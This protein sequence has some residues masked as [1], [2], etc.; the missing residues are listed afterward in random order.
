VSEAEGSEAGRGRPAPANDAHPGARHKDSS[1]PV[2]SV[3]LALIGRIRREQGYANL[4]LSH[5]AELAALP[6]RD[7]G[8]VTRLVYGTL[9]MEGSLDAALKHV[10]ERGRLSAPPAVLDALRLGAYQLL[11][12]D[13]AVHAAVGETVQTIT[14]HPVAR[15]RS[16][17]NALL[18]RLAQER[19]GFP[20]LERA[21]HPQEWLALRYGHPRWLV[22]R[23]L[24][25][26]GEAETEEL[27]AA[28]DEAPVTHIRAN[29][30]RV[31][32]DDLLA[33]LL[34]RGYDARPGTLPE[35]ILVA[36]PPGVWAEPEAGHEFVV[37]DGGSLLAPMLLDPKPGEMVLDMAAGRGGKATHLAALMGN[38]GEV[39]A[40]DVHAGKARQ[41]EALARDM[42]AGIV[43]CEVGDARSW[44]PEA[45]FD[46]VLLD[47]PCS[48]TGT[49]RRRAELRWRRTPE[50]VARVADLQR[51]LLDAA[52]GHV[53]AGGR[54]VYSTCS[55]LPEENSLQIDG[56]LA[57]ASGT[58]WRLVRSEQLL[59]SRDG[60]D[61]HFAALL[62]R[63]T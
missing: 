36:G 42:G 4:V 5:S 52:A 33:K 27:L 23:L 20:W 29:T 50:D 51:T 7:R 17:A 8:L 41:C 15:W 49:L 56:F 48:G 44:E 58:A 37:Q 10:T 12:S 60:T 61:G 38:D 32:R 30:L 62:E 1:R 39:V 16:L 43:R 54:L 25:A 34:E 6:P 46:A 24:A 19:E 47:A 55:I 9:Q 63:G 13:V 40:L 28:D 35:G 26:Y 45:R 2:R 59:P 22:E 11:F 53:R 57:S 18:R 21:D 3:A 31:S 14:T